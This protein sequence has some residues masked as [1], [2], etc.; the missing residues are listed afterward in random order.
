MSIAWMA[1]GLSLLGQYPTDSTP[2]WLSREDT[3]WKQTARTSA[4]SRDP[5]ARQT[6]AMA[7][8]PDPTPPGVVPDAPV[9]PAA[10]WEVAGQPASAAVFAEERSPFQSDHEFDSFI[11]PLSNPIQ[12]K[13]PR[14]LTE[15]RFVFLNNY[16]RSNIPVLGKGTFQVYALQLRLALSDRLQIFADKD[17]IVR[18]NP[19]VGKSYTGLA[20]I[21]AGAKYV[22]YRNVETQ[23]LFSV[24]AQYEPPT[25]SANIF[26]N[27][28]AGSLGV[29]GILGKTFGDEWH[30]LLQAG[31][32]F[33]MDDVLSGYFMTSAHI[34]KRFGKFVPFYEA[35]WFYYNQNGNFLPASVGI[36]GG[37]LL[38]LGTKGV[39]GLNFVTNA[40]GFKYDFNQHAELGVAYEFRVS[41][42]T[43][44]LN[45]M[46]LVEMIFRY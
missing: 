41:D 29:Y 25:G 33:R 23:T 24:A 4:P 32:S 30:L 20:N 37:G 22:V 17:G 13:D 28:G 10:P 19:Q 34:D 6:Q 3:I 38:N 21:N 31:Q 18:F 12:F 9:A 14:S 44:L 11:G 26:Q 35:N 39:N 1:V 40:V 7:P 42:R 36:E 43:M 16:G 45:Q 15:A 27:Q 2:G 5:F 46:L 8:M